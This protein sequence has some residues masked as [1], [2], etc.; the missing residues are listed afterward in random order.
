MH[1]Y[2][3]AWKNDIS[4]KAADSPHCRVHNLH[5]ARVFLSNKRTL[6]DSKGSAKNYSVGGPLVGSC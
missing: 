2:A 4:I 5:S 6:L 3:D 1:P